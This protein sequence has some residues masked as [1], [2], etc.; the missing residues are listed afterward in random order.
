MD[1]IIEEKILPYLL[2]FREMIGYKKELPISEPYE[3][4]IEQNK[5]QYPNADSPGVYIFYSESAG[6]L[7]IGKCSTDLGFRI[8]SHL[9]KPGKPSEP[10]PNAEKWVKDHQKENLK[11]VTIPFIREHYFLA[12][13]LEEYLIDK[14]KP[15]ANAIGKTRRK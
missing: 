8:W 12:S 7:Y 11:F 6:L 3:P 9:Q 4:Y 14:C 10:Y 1:K 2:E 5:K 13:A 15:K